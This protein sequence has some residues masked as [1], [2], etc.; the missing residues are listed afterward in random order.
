MAITESERMQV[1][2]ADTTTEL[3]EKSLMYNLLDRRWEAG[4][5]AGGAVVHIPKPLWT[6]A[7]D[8][9]SPS[10][11]TQ[12]G[13]WATARGTSQDTADLKRAGG[14]TASNEILWEDAMEL[15][16]G[17]V[18]RTVNRMTWALRHSL[19]TEIYDKVAAMPTGTGSTLTGGDAG[20]TYVS[21]AK[22]YK[23]T[24]AA[25][26]DHPLMQAIDMLAIEMYA[27]NAIDKDPSP[28]DVS[29]TPFLIAPPQLIVSLRQWMRSL[30]L[31][32]DPLTQEILSQNP[33]MAIAQGYIGNLSGVRLFSW[34]HVAVP[35]SGVNW[36]MYGGMMN[37]AAV[38]VR[39]P[40]MQYFSPETNQTSTMPAHL[41]RQA[42]DYAVVELVGAL[43]KKI[44]IHSD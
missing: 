35:A 24:I 18:T 41:I 8:G 10:T 31:H 22:P 36:S 6:H 33:G 42:G 27:Q 32:F 30:G 40:L 37:A 14:Y 1:Y 21:S 43:H 3:R 28:A 26:D 15:S 16:W 13:D 2:S 19:D 4:Y 5:V 29:G 34:N 20:A 25:G 44:V 23:A 7:T 12:G 11:R 9:V 38:G 39:P 17:V